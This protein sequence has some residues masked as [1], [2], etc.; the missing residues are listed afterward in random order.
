MSL[1]RILYELNPRNDLDRTNKYLDDRSVSG[2]GK[3]LGH[4]FGTYGKSMVRGTLAGIAF[5]VIVSPFTD[6][7]IEHDIAGGVGLIASIDVLQVYARMAS[8]RVANNV[9][10]LFKDDSLV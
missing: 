1:D 7:P 9:G 10:R 2:Y 6:A 8:A 3:Y 4:A 5:G